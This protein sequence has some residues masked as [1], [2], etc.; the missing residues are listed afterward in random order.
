MKSGVIPRLPNLHPLFRCR[1]APA[2]AIPMASSWTSRLRAGPVISLVS[3]QKCSHCPNSV[4]YPENAGNLHCAQSALERAHEKPAGWVPFSQPVPR[5]A[6]Q[7]FLDKPNRLVS[8][9]VL[10]DNVSHEN[11]RRVATRSAWGSTRENLSL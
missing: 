1:P 2:S 10:A 7:I 5:Y 3:R 11:S 9:T 4:A 8:V 6:I